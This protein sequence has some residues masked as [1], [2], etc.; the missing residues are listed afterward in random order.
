[1]NFDLEPSSGFHNS[2]DGHITS[3]KEYFSLLARVIQDVPTE[4]IDE[5]ARVLLRAYE[6][7][8]TVF[9]FGNGGSAALASHFACDLG[10][11]TSVPGSARKRFRVVALT[12][13]VPLLTAWANDSNYEEIFAEQLRNFIC[14]GDVCIAISGSGNSPNVLRAL[15][16]SR[17]SGGTNVG[18]TGFA[19]GKMK[20]LC[21]LCLVVPSDN[22]QLIEDVHLSVAHSIF[23]IVRHHIMAAPRVRM[24]AGNG[25]HLVIS[26]QRPD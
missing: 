15:Q 22:M 8:R 21:N 23:T 1:M 26:N 7:E 25:K 12:D 5:I 16:V 4:E 19:G 13:N 11:G 24:A 9:L 10:K 18:L 20:S 17:M 3:G 2:C 6:K 14:P